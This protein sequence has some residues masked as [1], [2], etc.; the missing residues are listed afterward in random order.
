MSHRGCGKYESFAA[1]NTLA[2]G[3]SCQIGLI[4]KPAATGARSA[5]LNLIDNTGGSVNHAILHG[6]GAAPVKVAFTA[7]TSAQLLA[8][9]KT[10]VSVSVSS[11]SST[12]TGKV[13]FTI[14]GKAAGSPT[15]S[16]GKAS[17]TL[18]AL[19]SGTHQVVA[20]YVGDQTHSAG[21]ASKTL[22]VK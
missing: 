19:T 8:G 21:K 20:A 5:T 6:T 17:V 2:A 4:F 10:S 14:D 9:T 7:P 13:N 3:Q 11:A 18:A 16:S 1:G 12:P 22:T 15:L